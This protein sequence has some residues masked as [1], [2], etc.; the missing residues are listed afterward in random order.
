MPQMTVQQAVD[1][2]AE[3]SRAGR[4][5]EAESIHRQLIAAAP[6]NPDHL[7]MLARLAFQTGQAAFAEDVLR[8]VAALEPRNLNHQNNLGMILAAQGKLDEAIGILRQALAL[9]PQSAE[10]HGNLANALAAKGETDAAIAEYLRAL[11]LRPDIAE[12][13]NNLANSLRTK[14]DLDAAIEHFRAAL[15]IR[16]GNLQTQTNL[17]LALKQKAR[18]EES[19]A[20][21]R[22]AVEMSPADPQSYLNLADTLQDAK[23]HQEAVEEYRRVLSLN[24]ASAEAN[25]GMGNAMRSIGDLADALAAYER[26][27][28]IKPDYTDAYNNLGV[29]LQEKGELDRAIDVLNRACTINPKY[30]EARNNLGIAYHEATRFLEAMEAYSAALAIKPDYSEA[31][32]NL[33][34]TLE[35]LGRIEEAIQLYRKSLEIRPD[36]GITRNNFANLLRETGQVEEALA[37]YR[38]AADRMTEPW[39]ASNLVF[40][41]HT[42]PEYGPQ[43]LLEE[44]LKWA[45]RYADPLYPPVPAFENDR[46]PDRRL[47]VGYVSPDFNEH[48]VGRFLLPMF[49]NRD[50]GGFEVYCYSGVKR[51]DD[52]TSQLRRLSDV[53]RITNGLTDQR[54]AEIIRQDRIDILIDLTMHLDGCRLLTFARKPAPVQVTYLAYCGTTGLRAIDY[55]ITDPYFD[56][57]GQYD[58]DYTEKSVRLAR[59]YWCYVA[60]R[61]APVPVEL[62]ALNTGHVT[63]GCMNNFSKISS[64]ATS[65]WARLLGAVPDS[66]LL[67]HCREGG[68]RDRIRTQFAEGGVDPSRID[69]VP[70]LPGTDYFLQYHRMDIALDPF[71]YPGGTTSCDALWMGV[72][73]V[74]L[75]GRTAISRGGV[76]IISNVGLPE[77]IAQTPEQYVEIAAGL[78]RDLDHLAKLRTRLRAQMQAS[79]LMDAPQFARDI[80]AAYRYM[81]REWCGAKN[82]G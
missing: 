77:L 7:G 82:S 14:G 15:A 52:I 69:F 34:L 27:I 20:A 74:T 63:F 30:V 35:K 11:E 42:L 66:R 71:P 61:Q 54:L 64:A 37:E 9:D 43:E 36:Q 16:P 33:A 81:W 70:R 6:G 50:R 17:A 44:H 75:A 68:H 8:R 67:L 10:A 72:P 76:S 48:P 1:V 23:R 53:W 51:P 62:P 19:I 40:L 31:M 49:G 65:T 57:P 59:T 80:E 29:T 13:H 22:A 60:P 78:S 3:L 4:A 5:A 47:R 25:Y 55:R 26:A 38:R 12:F 79:S 45:R 32:A 21:Y 41:L 2:A 46:S 39:A 56:P 24:G 58:S 28:A 73:V 18:W